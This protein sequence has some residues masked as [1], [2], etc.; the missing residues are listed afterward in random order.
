MS[1]HDDSIAEDFELSVPCPVCGGTL[2]SIRN[3]DGTPFVGVT[4]YLIFCKQCD[5]EEDEERW[6]MRL[7]TNV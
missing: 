2:V 6:Q 5:F 3:K 1:N 4:G 7:D